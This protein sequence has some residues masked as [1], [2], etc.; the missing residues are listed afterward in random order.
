[1]Q[2]HFKQSWWPEAILLHQSERGVSRKRGRIVVRVSSFVRVRHH[3]VGGGP[4]QE[5]C[6]FSCQIGE[7]ASGALIGNRQVN[8]LVGGDIGDRQRRQAFPS[9][10]LRIFAT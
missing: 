10:L 9:S 6:D 8:D 4:L 3:N 7:T 2:G 1:M 5:S